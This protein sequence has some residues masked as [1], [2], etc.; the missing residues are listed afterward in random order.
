M[1]QH[2]ADDHGVQPPTRPPEERVFLMLQ[3]PHGPFFDRL[4][5][6]LRAAG[7]TV[8]RCGFNAGDEFF[9]SDRARF[10]RHEGPVEDW[11]AHL[12]AILTDKGVTD[13]VL[14]GDVRQIHA[15]ARRMA[16]ERGITVHV[17]E[18]GY[19][20]PYWITYERGGSNGNSVLMQIPLAQMRAVLREQISEVRRPPAHWGDMRQHKFYGA[21]YH[22]LILLRNAR[23]RAY[24]GHRSISVFDEFRLNLRRLVM[25]P[26]YATTR[27]LQW[28]KLRLSGWPYSLVLMQLEHD[29]SFLGHSDF[30]RNAEFVDMVIDAFAKSAPRHH[31]LVF[32]AHPLE[33]GRAGNRRAIRAACERHGLTGRVHYIR[34]GKLADIM[35][36]ARAVV[37]VNSTGAQ[38]A[39][40]RGVPVKA[41]GRAVYDKPG[42]VSNQPLADFLAAPDAPDPQAYRTFRDYLLQTSQIPGG[43]YAGRSRAHALRQVADLMLAARDPYEALAAGTTIPRQQLDQ[44]K[45]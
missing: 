19:L 11:P 12:D 6:L 38:Q 20:R 22:F 13:L 7:S 21:F 35:A 2:P 1:F 15:E 5:R 24:R 9:W 10:L 30:R 27:T 40:W 14:Y 25:A 39:M 26:V 31:H 43:F 18:E 37:T 29:A 36:H 45:S 17:F 16:A 4:A 28:R 41:L 34:G 3:G 8:W 23:Y 44:G 42:L 32:K 33:D